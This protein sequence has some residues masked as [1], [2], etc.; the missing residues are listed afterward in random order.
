[1]A[2][3]FSF[4]GKS[5]PQESPKTDRQPAVAGKFYPASQDS[6]RAQLSD[7]F[8]TAKPR[9]VKNLQAVIC[10]HAGYVFSGPVAASGINQVDPDKVYD[11]IFIIGS[12]HQV[13]FMGASYIIRVI[14]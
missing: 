6:L 11:N 10:P 5:S 4:Q 8:H 3:T 9:T 7:L 2:L 13:S 14:T 1:M 12:S